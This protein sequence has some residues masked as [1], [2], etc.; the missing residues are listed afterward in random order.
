M[1]YSDGGRIN[2]DASE[3]A[4]TV[5]LTAPNAEKVESKQQSDYSLTD[6]LNGKKEEKVV[7]ITSYNVCY[8]KLLRGL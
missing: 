5:A 6:V 7:R 2:V 4:S 1:Q 3:I 8:T